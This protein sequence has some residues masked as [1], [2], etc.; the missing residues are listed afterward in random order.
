MNTGARVVGRTKTQKKNDS[1]ARYKW[2]KVVFGEIDSL[3]LKQAELEK[4][5]DKLRKTVNYISDELQKIK[6]GEQDERKGKE[7]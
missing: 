5:Q 7:N 4:K 2:L 1:I 6:E 3:K